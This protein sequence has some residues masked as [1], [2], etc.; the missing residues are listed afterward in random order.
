MAT[1]KEEDA[2]FS[3]IPQGH[4]ARKLY[5]YP[6]HENQSKLM[7]LTDRRMLIVLMGNIRNSRWCITLNT[8]RKSS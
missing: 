5:K 1:K 4:F 7:W 8:N 6:N 3:K 2:D